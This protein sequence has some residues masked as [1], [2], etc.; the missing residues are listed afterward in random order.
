[1]CFFVCV[2]AAGDLYD[3]LNG[4]EPELSKGVAVY[5]ILTIGVMMKLVLWIY[6]TVANKG[7][8]GKEKSDMLSALAEDHLNDVVS[9]T[10]AV[11]TLAIAAHTILWWFDPIGC[12]V[13][14]VAICSRWVDIMQDQ[15][16]KVVGMTAP[17]EFI[18]DLE[19]LVRKHDDRIVDIDRVLAYHS[20]SNYNVEVDILLPL[21]MTVGE[22]H[23]IAISIQDV[24]EEQSEVERANIHVCCIATLYTCI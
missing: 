24:L 21:S 7:P 4:N 22:S 20:G 12:I 19:S 14:S 6:C 11:I 9:N 13:I 15:T 16:Q 23:D 2:E 3:G 5:I 1:M 8:D 17:Q 18:D 10:V